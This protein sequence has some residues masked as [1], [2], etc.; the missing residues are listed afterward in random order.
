MNSYAL[1]SYTLLPRPR[2]LCNH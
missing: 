1:T 2:R